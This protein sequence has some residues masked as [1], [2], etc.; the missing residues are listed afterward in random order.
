MKIHY[1]SLKTL[2][3][4]KDSKND[5][6]ILSH[7]LSPSKQ[8]GSDAAQ[9]LMGPPWFVHAFK[10]GSGGYQRLKP[11]ATN[12]APK[13]SIWENLVGTSYGETAA[14]NADPCRDRFRLPPVQAL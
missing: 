8:N 12:H 14:T 9:N 5:D 11:L 1:E 3:L 13:V 7:K 10:R 4:A 6:V 2:I